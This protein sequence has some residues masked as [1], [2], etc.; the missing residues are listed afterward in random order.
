MLLRRA[1]QVAFA[2]LTVAL[3]VCSQSGRGVAVSD[4]VAIQRRLALVIG[5]STY[6][7]SPLRNPT[8]DAADIASALRHLNF[9]VTDAQNLTLRD[10][11]RITDS[12]AQG[13]RPGDLVF[14]Y[15]AGHGVQYQQENYLIPIDYRARSAADLRYDALPAAQIRDR[16]ESS[17]ATVRVIV[18]DAC[19]DN[20]FSGTRSGTRGLAPMEVAEGTL[21]A[22]AT[23]DGRTA[24]DNPGERNGLYTKFLL[25]SLSQPGIT[26]RQAFDQTRASVFKAS[27]KHQLPFLYEGIVGDVHLAPVP[28]VPGSAPSVQPAM[29]VE[30]RAWDEIRN[31]QSIPALEAFLREFPNGAHAGLARVRLAVLRGQVQP[32]SAL[33]NAS[34][35]S[36]TQQPT[37]DPQVT[38]AQPTPSR[39][40]PTNVA[41]MSK[42]EATLRITQNPLRQDPHETVLPGTR[43]TN[44]RDGLAYIWVP[45][46]SFDM[47][48][49]DDCEDAG[50]MYMFPH[51]REQPPVPIQVRRGY[52][53]GQTEVTQEAFKKVTGR[54]PSYFSGPNLPVEQVTWQSSQSYCNSIGGRLPTEAEWEYAA[55]FGDRGPL[56]GEDHGKQPQPQQTHEVG[57]DRPNSLGIH[58]MQGNV[59]EWTTDWF[60]DELPTNVDPL[61]DSEARP[62][63]YKT[64]RGSAFNFDSRVSWRRPWSI[65]SPFLGIGFRC[66]VQ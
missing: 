53:I 17:G 18:L 11:D 22:Y 37:T 4:D 49:S 7:D 65:T 16:L 32:P 1:A 35:P 41:R 21:V 13:L 26:L 44:P 38:A 19:R 10:M 3:M 50:A 66:V 59:S 20:P 25:Q 58:D 61:S 34:E 24:D 60:S 6:P 9:I 43:R 27:S 23:A 46:G 64:V 51:G 30:A 39:V 14:F 52:W 62:T 57:Q 33:P 63:Q 36:T 42:T 48:C 54:A 15:Y 12:F 40:T 56:Y 29:D 5:N 8:N 55:R 2:A 45:P 47:G 31:M 28:T